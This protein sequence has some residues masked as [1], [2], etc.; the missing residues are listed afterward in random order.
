[1][2]RGRGNLESVWRESGRSGWHWER[3]ALAGFLQLNEAVRRA[4]SRAQT[5]GSCTTLSVAVV[6]PGE[7]L[8]LYASIGDSHLFQANG[9][10]AIDHGARSS[11]QVR[12]ELGSYFLGW[13]DETET[14]LADKCRVGT[15][16]LAST[17]AIVLAT[18][19]IS[20]RNIGHPDAGAAVA[21]SVL[22]VSSAPAELRPLRLAR[23]VVESALEAHGRNRAGDNVAVASY[24][25][26]PIS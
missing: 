7:G 26:E 10:T 6:R 1:M 15:D 8:L 22:E 25:L 17:R 23:A 16:T 19:G 18:D 3:S 12:R 11:S 2:A 21:Q 4:A 5:P 9:T 14:S 20:E 13:G 24:W